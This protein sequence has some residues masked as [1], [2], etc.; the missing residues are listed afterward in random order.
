MIS[1]GII[2]IWDLSSICML[3]A[4]EWVDYSRK[5]HIDMGSNLYIG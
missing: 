5:K 3:F 1:A 4:V 2:Y